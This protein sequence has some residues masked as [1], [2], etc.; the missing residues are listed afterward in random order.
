MLEQA[1]KVDID[2]RFVYRTP[3][4]AL[5]SH[6]ADHQQHGLTSLSERTED[7]NWLDNAERISPAYNQSSGDDCQNFEKPDVW[8]VLCTNLITG[9]KDGKPRTVVRCNFIVFT[10]AIASLFS[11]SSFVFA[12]KLLAT[13]DLFSHEAGFCCIGTKIPY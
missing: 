12:M 13:W 9:P 5:S 6:V 4:M 3:D 8:D 11:F 10:I 7:R 2:S 1:E